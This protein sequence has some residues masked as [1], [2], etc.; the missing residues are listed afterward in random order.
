VTSS[1]SG[2]GPPAASA[3]APPIIEARAVSAGYG[4]V[5]IVRE[6]DLEV[7]PGEIV[8]L[9]GANGAGKTTT[10][11]CLAGELT[12]V[13]GV[14]LWRGEETVAPLHRRARQGLRFVTES[15]SVFMGLTT[16]DNLRLGRGSLDRALDIFPEL[17]PLLRRTAG[18]LSGGEQQMLT[19][20][21]ALS[22]R[23]AL[24]LADE[25]SLGLAPVVVERLLG[26]LRAAADAGSAVLLVEQQIRGALAVADRAYVIRRGQVLFHGSSTEMLRRLGEIE[27]SY[28]AGVEAADSSAT[29][30]DGR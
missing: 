16:A 25:L 20:A 14:V 26:A 15:R 4:S 23:P 22:C 9:L 12:P 11:L 21:R 24:L 2:A 30:S 7:R 6:L 28:L 10:L 29:R 13:A 27:A 18:L 17:R 5:P 19:L 8:A 3:D 1:V